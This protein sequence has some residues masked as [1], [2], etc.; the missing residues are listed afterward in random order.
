MTALILAATDLAEKVRLLV[1]RGANVNLAT[2][3]GRTALFIA[4]MSEHSAEIARLLIAKGA[5]VKAMD[6]F[7]NTMLNAAAAGNDTE[8]IRLMLDAGVDVNAAATTGLTPLM[9]AAG[10]SNVRVVK[11]LLAKDTRRSTRWGRRSWLPVLFRRT[12]LLSSIPTR[13]CIWRW[14]PVRRTWSRRSSTRVPM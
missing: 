7:K 1:D 8:T 6:A 13:R 2:K 11:T 4:A 5:N 3:L 9:L 12:D 14:L 10:Q